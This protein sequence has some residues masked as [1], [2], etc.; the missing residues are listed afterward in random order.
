MTLYVVSS[1]NTYDVM[2]ATDLIVF[3]HTLRTPLMS[4]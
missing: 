2:T 1:C 4:A 3:S